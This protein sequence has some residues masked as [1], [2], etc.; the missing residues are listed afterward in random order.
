MDLGVFSI[1]VLISF[2]SIIIGFWKKAPYLTVLGG[3]IM[4]F[5]GVFMDLDGGFTTSE[6]VY[7]SNSTAVE[8]V[9]HSLP[10]FSQYSDMQLLLGVLFLFI[11]IG[12]II[13][14]LQ[15]IG[16]RYSYER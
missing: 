1:F 13:D 16:D 6:C 12:V 15:R 3:M 2:L 4:I 5:L 9:N 14:S 10:T 8:C 7:N 11:G